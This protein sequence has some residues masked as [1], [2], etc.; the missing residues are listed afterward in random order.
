[1]N[2]KRNISI[3]SFDKRHSSNISELTISSNNSS[4]NSVNSDNHNN[5]MLKLNDNECSNKKKTI[6]TSLI[7]FY[8]II[9]NTNN[10]NNNNN[11]CI[12]NNNTIK[13]LN[14]LYEIKEIKQNHSTV[15][16][17]IHFNNKNIE[18]IDLIN[19]YESN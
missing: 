10:I 4:Y 19:N 7:N 17:Y 14:N 18:L 13:I 9:N 15:L 3:N 8:P 1:M 12:N 6:Q 5:N 2:F 11:N 16:N